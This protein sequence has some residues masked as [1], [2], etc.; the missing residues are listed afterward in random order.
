[1]FQLEDISSLTDFQR[2]A[3]KHLRQMKK[4]GRPRVLT[5]NGKAEA[6]LLGSKAYE[7]LLDAF[8]YVEAVEGIKK[9]LEEMA[10]G[11]GIPLEEFDA[12][13]RKKYKFLR[14]K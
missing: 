10:Q 6:I 1:M 14:R 3:R 5:V 11:K 8:E 12:R 7:K 4:T 9:G 2:N 13:M